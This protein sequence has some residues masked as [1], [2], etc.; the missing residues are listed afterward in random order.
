MLLENQFDL[1]DPLSC[2]FSTIL[3]QR[4]DQH[5]VS[6]VE[7]TDSGDVGTH[8]HTTHTHTHT[9]TNTHRQTLTNVQQSHLTELLIYIFCCIMLVSSLAPQKDNP[10]GETLSNPLSQSAS[11]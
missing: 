6:A 5:N 10:I 8:T 2:Q 3:K 9:R 11:L 4:T 1:L 7:F